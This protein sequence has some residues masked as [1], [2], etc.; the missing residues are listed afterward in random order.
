M[1]IDRL[2]RDAR[3]KSR[4]SQ[5]ALAQAAK[6]PRSTL[7]RIEAGVTVDP[8][9]HTVARLLAPTGHRLVIC[10][11][12]DI[13]LREDH[14]E[15]LPFDRGGRRFPPHLPLYEIKEW[16][17][18]WGWFRIAWTMR[19]RTVPKWG[20][21]YPKILSS[22]DDKMAGMTDATDA[23]GRTVGSDASDGSRDG[24]G[25][26]ERALVPTLVAI[27]LV[28]AIMSSLGAPLIPTIALADHVSISTGQWLLTSTLLAGA[29]A[30]PIM[31][32][33]A[34]G[35][36]R[37]LVIIVALVVVLIGSV[38]A[39][40]F[41]GFAPL[42]IGRSMQ[43]VGLGLVPV[44]M[45]IA[46]RHLPRHKSPKVIGLLS[47]TAAMGI[48]LGYPIT[49]L[50]AESFD[51]HVAFWFGAAVVAMALLMAILVL[52]REHESG[53]SRLDAIGAA[54]FT[55]V[56]L[57]LL[58][59][60]SQG[61]MWGWLSVRVI[62]LFVIALLVGVLWVLYEL[63]ATTPLVV[64][65]HLRIR[66]VVIVDIC[67][68]FLGIA[69]YLFVP[70]IVEFVQ[71]P[72]SEGYGFGVSITI[73]GLCLVPLSVGTGVASFY[74]PRLQDLFGAR[75]TFMGGQLLLAA[76]LTFFALWHGSLWEA[77]VTM[78]LGGVGM[79]LG[80]GTMPGFI[81]AAVPAHE[82]GTA[83]GLYQ[84]VRSTGLSIGSAA[85]AAILAAY[86]R[87]HQALPDIA[88]YRTTLLVAAVL[89]VLVATLG[90]LLPQAA[91]RGGPLTADSVPEDR[92]PGSVVVD[93][94]DAG[95]LT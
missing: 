19:D 80:W 33:L 68:G 90:L 50:I 17:R 70:V 92:Q 42:V 15:D 63:R 51:Y 61:D 71:I 38:I 84:V 4:L 78:G 20:Y 10:D 87:S 89:C 41:D 6:M 27:A 31:G 8:G 21:W 7:D 69:M 23:T 30:S 74:V 53:P 22:Y 18:W 32:Q 58:V 26:H 64:L 75:S 54:L 59:A 16:D 37:R 93:V 13:E 36:S 48:G 49:G 35:R 45:V 72:R 83:M 62:G 95:A 25:W 77:F 34:D 3:R 56:L 67:G 85:S 29:I 24:A 76:G 43:G 60:L 44:G 55:V 12:D 57:A 9:I 73:A 88:G 47:V 65:G 14:P 28:M 39:A 40:Q 79:G 81:I 1:Q 94:A 91:R 46:R 52:P 2:I 86:T 11:D 5:R 66:S 82:T